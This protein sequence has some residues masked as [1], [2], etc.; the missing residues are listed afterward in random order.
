MKRILNWWM[1]SCRSVY[2]GVSYTLHVLVCGQGLRCAW[3]EMSKRMAAIGLVM[4]V[5]IRD[6]RLQLRQ[7]KGS[8]T[9]GTMA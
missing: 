3:M 1:G 4:V 2:Q 7:M 9:Q 6:S 8:E 5:M